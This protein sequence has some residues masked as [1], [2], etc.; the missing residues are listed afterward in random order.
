MFV[1]MNTLYAILIFFNISISN[2]IEKNRCRF[3]IK[4]NTNKLSEMAAQP[5]LPE[6]D[7]IAPVQK[8]GDDTE[9]E[10]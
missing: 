4:P 1:K 5:A 9:G 2:F 6:K 8:E 3:N 10:N 7:Q